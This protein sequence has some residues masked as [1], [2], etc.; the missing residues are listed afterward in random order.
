MKLSDYIIVA[1]DKLLYSMLMLIV[2]KSSI[3]KN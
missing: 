3:I 2:F 1:Y